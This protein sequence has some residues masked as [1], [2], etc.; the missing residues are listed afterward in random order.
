MS[1]STKAIILKNTD[2][3][4]NDRVV[5]I[6]SR[7]YGKLSL[8]A[9]SV[10]KQSS[11]LAGHLIELNCSLIEFTHGKNFLHIIGAE[12]IANW[13][14]TRLYLNKLFFAR[15]ACSLIDNFCE[16]DYAVPKIWQMLFDLLSLMDSNDANGRYLWVLSR[17]FQASLIKELGLRPRTDVCSKCCR[18]IEAKEGRFIFS[19]RDGSFL[20][21]NCG[22]NRNAQNKFYVFK[23]EDLRV[24]KAFLSDSKT[25]LVNALKLAYN[26][27]QIA[28][29]FTDYLSFSG[30]LI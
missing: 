1:Y 27:N 11:K 18:T 20:H 12:T 9:K 3:A 7:E 15:Y 10:R 16:E 19:F 13:Q 24:V 4:E 28:G 26:P 8:K 29:F 14:I 21:R 25:D 2:F 17:Q 5:H 23:K 22:D 30:G 6:L